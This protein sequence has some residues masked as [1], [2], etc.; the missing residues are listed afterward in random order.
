L[1]DNIPL[2]DAVSW[3]RFPIMVPALVED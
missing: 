3:V 2:L 1:M